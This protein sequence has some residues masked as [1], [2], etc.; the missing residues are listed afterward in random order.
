M[1]LKINYRDS[2]DRYEKGKFKNIS[3]E[4]CVCDDFI[5]K[6]LKTFS[7]CQMHMK[8]NTKC[9][10]TG[11]TEESLDVKHAIWE[12]Y[13]LCCLVFTSVI[14][15]NLWNTDN[16]TNKRLY[17]RTKAEGYCRISKEPENGSG[18]FDLNPGET[19]ERSYIRRSGGWDHPTSPLGAHWECSAPVQRQRDP[20]RTPALTHKKQHAWTGSAAQEVEN[21]TPGKRLEDMSRSIIFWHTPSLN[22]KL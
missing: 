16:Q 13:P 17:S 8:R 22:P 6:R 2:F 15:F 3:S 18:G 19:S 4:P 11:I 1:S 14:W 5:P 20:S 7:C 21:K 10:F 9:V 12:M